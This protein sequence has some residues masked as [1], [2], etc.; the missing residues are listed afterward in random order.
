[1]VPANP[2]RRLRIGY[3]P[4]QVSLDR[5]QGGLPAPVRRSSSASR[6]SSRARSPP[7]GAVAGV[8]ASKITRSLSMPL[9]IRRGAWERALAAASAA[10]SAPSTSARRSAASSPSRCCSSTMILRA[11]AHGFLSRSRTCAS[12]AA[13]L[14]RSAGAFSALST[15]A[16]CPSRW[17]RPW[18]VHVQR[19][20]LLREVDRRQL[21]PHAFNRS[22]G[23]AACDPS[24]GR[25]SGLGAAFPPASGYH[26][27]PFAGA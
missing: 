21:A 17:A 9:R 27:V 18:R 5:L 10:S 12:S 20:I 2:F 24:L 1:M 11:Q 15:A 3:E 23:D 14:A 25:F 16:I 19:A 26:C 6:H 4:A 8:S 22:A 13:G 7:A